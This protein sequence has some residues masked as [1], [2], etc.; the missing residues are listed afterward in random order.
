M[1]RSCAAFEPLDGDHAAAAAG[2][3]ICRLRLGWAIGSGADCFDDIDGN[4]W[5]RE[6]LAG[7][8]DV[9][10]ALAAGEQAVVADA[11]ETGGQY[12]H[13]ETADELGGSQSHV[14]DARFVAVVLPGEGDMIVRNVDKTAIGDSDAVGVPAEIAQH[15]FGTGKGSLAVDNP[16]KAA[17]GRKVGSERAGAGQMHEIG[18]KT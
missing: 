11:M 17:E 12:V 3:E 9:L 8:A 4:D 10:G 1:V 6:Q 5:R 18:E 13:Q 14:R 16:A 7:T 15:L 2:A